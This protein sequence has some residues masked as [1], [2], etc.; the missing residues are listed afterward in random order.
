MKN[1]HFYFKKTKKMTTNLGIK[2]L[3]LFRKKS[4]IL[5]CLFVL[6]AIYLIIA[7]VGFVSIPK[8]ANGKFPL[9]KYDHKKDHEYK[10]T[11]VQYNYSIPIRVFK[12]GDDLIDQNFIDASKDKCTNLYEYACG[13]YNLGEQNEVTNIMRFENTIMKQWI[14]KGLVEG[15]NKMCLIE[16]EGCIN[17]INYYRNCVYD[18]IHHVSPAP[19]INKLIKGMNNFTNKFHKIIQVFIANKTI[20]QKIN[21]IIS[22]E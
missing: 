7:L 3:N 15:S 22:L 1:K 16:G 5:K 17:A 14:D 21:Y 11:E 6:L 20:K 12:T 9:K 2:V 10:W 19:L 4:C 13:K 18:K 8:I